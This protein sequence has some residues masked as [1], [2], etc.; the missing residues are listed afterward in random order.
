MQVEDRAGFYLAEGSGRMASSEATEDPI[1]GSFGKNARSETHFWPQVSGGTASDSTSLCLEELSSPEFF[2]R[3]CTEVDVMAAKVVGQSITQSSIK[4]ALQ[5]VLSDCQFGVTITDPSDPDMP[6]IAASDHYQAMTGYTKSELLR[7]SSRTLYTDRSLDGPDL[8]CLRA[9][10][11]TGAGFTAL[12][13]SQRKSGEYYLS[14]LD[15]RG[16]T[17]AHDPCTGEELWYLVGIHADMTHIGESSFRDNLPD[18]TNLITTIRNE[19]VHHISA[20]TVS[21][22]LMSN[23][24]GVDDG[25]PCEQAWCLLPEP[26]WKQGPQLARLLSPTG[27]FLSFTAPFFGCPNINGWSWLTLDSKSSARW[28]DA[29]FTPEVVCSVTSVALLAYGFGVTLR[30]LVHCTS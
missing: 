18:I 20:M 28:H 12:I 25:E 17:I 27:G 15:L 22:M 8:I 11:E 30:Q 1:A 24:E 5:A 23:F 3:Q 26:S 2:S 21:G 10:I 29:L 7:S 14:V 4:E 16:L 13:T 6:I 19:L 9:A